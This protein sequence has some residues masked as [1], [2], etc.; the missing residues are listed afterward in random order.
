[1]ACRNGN[2]RPTNSFGAESMIEDFKK[3][4]FDIDVVPHINCRRFRLV[5]SM[6]VPFWLA[7]AFDKMLDGPPWERTVGFVT[8]TKFDRESCRVHRKSEA[9]AGLID[10]NTSMGA[11][12]ARYLH[13]LPESLFQPLVTRLPQVL[14][15]ARS[16]P[17]PDVREP[18]LSMLNSVHECIQPYYKPV[19]SSTRL[20]S[21]GT[22]FLNM[23]TVLRD[24]LTCDWVKCDL[25][26]AQLRFF[27]LIW[28]DDSLVKFLDELK[29]SFW[30][31]IPAAAGV[32]YS[33]E[34]K[35]A[36]KDATYAILYGSSKSNILVELKKVVGDEAA[37]VILNLPVYQLLFSA[38][39][40]AQKCLKRDGFVLD[41]T[42]RRL[43]LATWKE[44]EFRTEGEKMR[45]ILACQAQ[46]YELPILHPAIEYAKTTTDRTHP[47]YVTAWLHDGIWLHCQDPVLLQQDV[48]KV[49]QLVED[50]SER[51]L[52]A[53]IPLDVEMPK[54]SLC[55]AA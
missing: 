42:G 55:K 11:D 31:E 15:T 46:S 9:D 3:T 50:A 23:T 18:Q 27:A 44:G 8:G 40:R 22:N 37:V 47:L 28:K 30:R 13:E 45:S 17:S 21:F 12:V 7:G 2:L 39:R 32:V 43:E 36:I 38:A 25:K 1:M 49:Q 4:I 54:S 53:R 16:I 6:T 29:Q 14:R 24:E 51:L 5:R 52:G 33:E 35:R 10:T 26:Q 34:V 48:V 41:A 19:S 20:Y